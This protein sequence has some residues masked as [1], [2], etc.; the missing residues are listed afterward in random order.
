MPDPQRTK[1]PDTRSGAVD[2]QEN[3]ETPPARKKRVVSATLFRALFNR[4]ALK[5]AGNP[6]RNY[7]SIP[8][9]PPIPPMPW[10]LGLAPSFSSTSSARSEE[11]TSELQSPYEIVCRLLLE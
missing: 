2:R 11:H 3:R 6:R 7:I 5:L 1:K 4:P 9:M 10:P 8:G